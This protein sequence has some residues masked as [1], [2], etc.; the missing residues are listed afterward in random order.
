MKM[1]SIN[2]IVKNDRRIENL[3]TRLNEI[4]KPEKTEIVVVD[5]SKK[6]TL[7]DI[8]KKFPKVRWFY[9][10]NKTSKK[11][12]YAEQRNFG[13]KKSK[14]DIIVFIDSDCNPIDGWLIELTRLIKSGKEKI[15]QGAVN[16]GY[17]NITNSKL[18]YISRC[19]TANLAYSKKI[20]NKIGGY[21]ES[22]EASSDAEFGIRAKK[23]GYKILYNPKPLVN[24]PR[25]KPKKTIRNGY[26]H[27]IGEI[28]ILRKHPDQLKNL[29]SDLIYIIVYPL[30]IIFLPLTF[31]WRYYPLL[32]LI[33]III[34]YKR[35]PLKE[36][37][38]LAFGLGVLKQLFFPRRNKINIKE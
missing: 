6:E 16:R 21:D 13:V 33:P 2:I 18:G 1:I 30:F 19:D 24:H 5:A 25:D 22:F 37:V 23:A 3:L 28:N 36:I 32:I 27:G 29:S 8:K 10:E 4:L 14:G 20:V 11:F 15:V 17:M 34:H 35:N 7:L 26:I 9:F 31:F 38:N 12:T